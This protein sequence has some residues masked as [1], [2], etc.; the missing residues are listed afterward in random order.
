MYLANRIK[1]K[2]GRI[3]ALV[4]IG[5]MISTCNVYSS[6]GE[7]KWDPIPFKTHNPS[8]EDFI[9]E[10]TPTDALTQKVLMRIQN[11]RGKKNS[12]ESNSSVEGGDNVSGFVGGNGDFTNFPNVVSMIQ[13]GYPGKF[14]LGTRA[15]SPHIIAHDQY[16]NRYSEEFGVDPKLMRALMSQECY[17][18]VCD[19][20]GRAAWGPGQIEYTLKE[21]FKAFG[22]EYFNRPLAITRNKSTDDRLNP[23]YNIAFACYR[24]AQQLEMYEGDYVKAL[25]AY[26]FSHYSLN[27]LLERFPNGNEW[28][29]KRDKMAHYNGHL[30]RT[31]SSS[32]GD[33][34]YVEHVLSYYH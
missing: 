17:D 26:N 33:P 3:L 29:D 9:D 16:T 27:K 25:Q 31:G 32:Y 24:F 14:T 13:A 8:S 28:L 1:L 12:S 19:G 5:I 11:K 6:E 18:G 23:E 10:L 22:L 2:K 7:L 34:K 20:N 30:R 15:V 21:E 4:L